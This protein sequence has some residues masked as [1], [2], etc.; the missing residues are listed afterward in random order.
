MLNLCKTIFKY[1][2]LRCHK[3]NNFMCYFQNWQIFEKKKRVFEK[4]VFLKIPCFFKNSV[5]LKIPCFFR[6]FRVF[7]K[8]PCFF[9]TRAHVDSLRGPGGGRVLRFKLGLHPSL[10][11]RGPRVAWKWCYSSAW[12]PRNSWG[13]NPSSN[14]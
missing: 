2:R 9:S 11:P 13:W 4:S 10:D 3:I 5:F 6:K 1:I 7:S 14:I 8:I 12:G